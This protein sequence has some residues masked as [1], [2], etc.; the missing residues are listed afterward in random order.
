MSSMSPTAEELELPRRS[1]PELAFWFRVLL[2]VLAFGMAGA[3]GLPRYIEQMPRTKDADTESRLASAAETVSDL[4][5]L[6]L[7]GD[8][9]AKL[10]E[11][12]RAAGVPAVAAPAKVT[13]AA[14]TVNTTRDGVVLALASPTGKHYHA[15][16]NPRGTYTV[17]PAR[18]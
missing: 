16:I 6:S 4:R 14:L 1:N 18:S 5:F 12:L 2:V 8:R 11:A 13:V 10:A 15:F 3:Y 7:K 17:R 9:S